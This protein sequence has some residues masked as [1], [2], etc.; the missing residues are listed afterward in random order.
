[1]AT[2]GEAGSATTNGATYSNVAGANLITYGSD[3]QVGST[4]MKGRMVE[5]SAIGV[6]ITEGRPDVVLSDDTY[7]AWSMPGGNGDAAMTQSTISGYA[8]RVK[9]NG[10]AASLGYALARRTI[11]PILFS[12]DDVIQFAIYVERGNNSRRFR[13][14]FATDA[15]YANKLMFDGFIG[16][17]K[18]GHNLISVKLAAGTYAG[19]GAS[20]DVWK[21][22]EFSFTG[23]AYQTE[24]WFHC[25]YIYV[26]KAPSVPAVIITFDAA[27]KKL[28]TWALP[29][30]RNLGIPGNVYVA[31]Y[32]SLTNTANYCSVA[33]LQEMRAAGWGFGCYGYVGSLAANSH[34]ATSVAT[35]QSVLAGA[36][37]TIDGTYASGGV[38]SLDK[39]RPISLTCAGDESA[40]AFTVTGIAA[41]GSPLTE[42]ISGNTA[43]SFKPYSVNRFYKVYS[44]VPTNN[45]AANVSVGTGYQGEETAADV[46]KNIAFLNK[47]GLSGD[48]LN[49]AMP[50]GEYNHETEPWLRNMGFVAARTASTG[51]TIMSNQLRR[52]N[53]L[54]RYMSSCAVTMGDTGGYSAFKTQLDNAI[55][56]GHDIY[57]L[58]HLNAATSTDRIDFDLGISYLSQL[59]RNGTIR[60]ETFASYETLLAASK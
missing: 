26:G 1:M 51:T 52:K 2:I 30:M 57:V 11:E 25:G 42:K 37:F 38:A 33:E 53:R 59:E 21:Y 8:A 29:T 3:G 41:N 17:M 60:I 5:N 28:Y 15:A 23:P 58:S 24:L 10:Q 55:S 6:N 7:S 47:Y 4:E 32:L 16:S 36:N 49:Y 48:P 54:N 46:Q 18:P 31:G 40:N 43:A 9:T 22:F 45:T 20:S 39:P 50:L 13:A 34:S 14:T 12:S 27:H 44:V 35:A 56:R 19:T